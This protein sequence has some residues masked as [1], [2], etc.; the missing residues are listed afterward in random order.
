MF[1]LR[2]ENWDLKKEITLPPK[3]HEIKHIS[4]YYAPDITS[5]QNNGTPAGQ[6]AQIR[7]QNHSTEKEAPPRA[8][9]RVR[10]VKNQKKQASLRT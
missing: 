2:E 8:M 1:L 7:K 10:L 9:S 4:H 5:R 3:R 6:S